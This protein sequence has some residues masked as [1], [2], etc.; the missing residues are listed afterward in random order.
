MIRSSNPMLTDSSFSRGG[1]VT[2][3]DEVMT[4]GGTVTKTLVCLLLAFLT[5]G[6]SWITFFQSGSNPASISGWMTVG[7][8]GGLAAVLVTAF[9]KEWSTYTA[10]IYALAEGFV[11]GGISALFEVRFPGIAIQATGLTFGTLAVMLCAYQSGFIRPTEKFKLGVIA[12]TGG[13]ALVY[14]ISFVMSLFGMAPQFLFG[15][16]MFGI[17][18]SLFVVG[19]AALNLVID[20]D[21]IEQGARR[22]LPKYYEWYGALALMVTLVWLYIE[23]LR[24]MSKFRSR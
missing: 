10:P 14:F 22:S 20:F 6:Y 13:I 8:I 2:Q 19:I 17:G 3:F 15:S 12:A 21:F 11:I 23:F 1:R 4:I 5:A 16:G 9:K 24:L 7:I 18:F